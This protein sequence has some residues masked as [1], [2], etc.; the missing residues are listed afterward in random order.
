MNFD[1]NEFETIV[2]KNVTNT[3]AISASKNVENAI[4]MACVG[5]IHS[6]TQWHDAWHQNIKAKHNANIINAD[7]THTHNAF[8]LFIDFNVSTNNAVIRNAMNKLSLMF[9]VAIFGK[10]FVAYKQ[11][12]E[13]TWRCSI[14]NTK[15]SLLA[16]AYYD[17]N[18]AD[19]AL[20]TLHFDKCN[21][22]SKKTNKS[23]KIDA[24]DVTNLTFYKAWQILS[25]NENIALLDLPSIKKF[26]NT[27]Q[28][29]NAA[30]YDNEQKAID[31][32]CEIVNKNVNDAKIA[33]DA[34][35]ESKKNAADKK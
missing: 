23:F 1:L 31:V 34:K 25:L 24:I 7:Y 26:F 21:I 29:D 18:H 22:V 14:S 27:W 20:H 33:N 32:F 9:D 28:R 2:T 15:N 16:N 12:N 3:K 10:I 11:L 13:T 35:I 4:T 5:T 8:N 30:N 6:K 19:V 17:Y